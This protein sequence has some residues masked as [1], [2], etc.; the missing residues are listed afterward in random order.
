VSRETVVN[1]H[2]SLG[3]ANIDAD[4]YDAFASKM[5]I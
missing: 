4:V 5:E 1:I 2:D 3:F